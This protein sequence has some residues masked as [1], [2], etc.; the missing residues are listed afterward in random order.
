[1]TTKDIGEKYF[2]FCDM[3]YENWKLASESYYAAY[4]KP[5]VK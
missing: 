3:V 2:D 1:M 4:V 5:Y